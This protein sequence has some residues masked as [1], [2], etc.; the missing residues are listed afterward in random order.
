ME[1]KVT[2]DHKTSYIK[3]PDTRASFK[4]NYPKGLTQRKWLKTGYLTFTTTQRINGSEVNICK[5]T[6]RDFLVRASVPSHAHSTTGPKF[7]ECVRAKDI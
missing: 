5:E 2:Q 1:Q 3:I 6:L 4:I 7:L